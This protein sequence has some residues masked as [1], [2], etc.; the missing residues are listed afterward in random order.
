MVVLAALPA[1]AD[2]R[3]PDLSLAVTMTL[4]LASSGLFVYYLHH[5]TTVMRVSHIIAAVGA[6]CRR[7][8]EEQYP[9]G[10][11]AR[12]VTPLPPPVQVIAAAQPGMVEHVELDRLAALAREHDCTLSVLPAPGDFV[13]AGQP[14]IAVHPLAGGPFPTTVPEARACVAVNL[15]V[16]RTLGQDVGF[17]FRQ[18]TDI[19]ERALSPGINDTTTAVRSVQE[20]HD[21][22][23]RGRPA[24][25]PNARR[26]SRRHPTRTGADA[27][28]RRL[29]RG[30]GRRRPAGRTRPAADHPT[31][32]RRTGGPACRGVAG[33]SARHRPQDRAPG[34]MSRRSP[35][36]SPGSGVVLA[37]VGVVLGIV[38]RSSS[39]ST[40][41][42]TGSTASR[43]SVPHGHVL[44]YERAPALE[45][46]IRIGGPE[47]VAAGR[48]AVREVDDGADHGH[49]LRRFRG[50]LGGGQHQQRPSVKSTSRTTK[51]VPVTMRS[52]VAVTESEKGGQACMTTLRPTSH[53]CYAG[54]SRGT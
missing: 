46:A 28:L 51:A 24:R 16:E 47:L 9:A 52:T 8:I 21:L 14:L 13:V 22:L 23:R 10:P 17:G 1:G 49:Q 4:V 26:R 42:V 34:G 50:G 25:S 29:P 30:R 19:A 40:T 3:L 12:P 54:V 32:G 20:M 5:V 33:T 41:C 27:G 39:R 37:I 18:L 43:R 38:G 44:G 35:P 53:G 36:S 7:V 45:V 48:V 2:A 15:G 31:P 11:A 6:Q